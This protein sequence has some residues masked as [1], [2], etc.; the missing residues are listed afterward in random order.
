MPGA[1][2]M[3]LGVAAGLVRLVLKRRQGHSMYVRLRTL[4]RG[5]RRL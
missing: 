4:G 2:A 3:L 5:A 1:A